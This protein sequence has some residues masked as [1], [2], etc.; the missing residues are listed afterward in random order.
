MSEQKKEKK[1]HIILYYFTL[2]SCPKVY[3]KAESQFMLVWSSCILNIFLVLC[4]WSF[5]CRLKKIYSYFPLI[6][7][8]G[9]AIFSTNELIELYFN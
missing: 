8:P 3:A 7:K 5:F 4:N 9:K 2:F 6:C 1:I